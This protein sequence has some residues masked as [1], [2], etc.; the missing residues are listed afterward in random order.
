[1]IHGENIKQVQIPINKT[2][3]WLFDCPQVRGFGLSR[4]VMPPDS[5]IINEPHRYM[6]VHAA[7]VALWSAVTLLL[8]CLL[9]TLTIAV[10]RVKRAETALESSEQQKR[11]F[12]REAIFSVTDGKLQICEADEYRRLHPRRG[13]RWLRPAAQ[14][15]YR[16]SEMPL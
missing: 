2:F 6:R 5:I 13:S 14:L 7:L 11:L 10:K 4:E 12:Y 9:V 8:L 1:M 16:A 3:H 15:M